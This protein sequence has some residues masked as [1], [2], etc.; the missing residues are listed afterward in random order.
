MGRKSV[1]LA[2][3]IS[4][5]R[6]GRN[7]STV[8]SHL[9]P[10]DPRFP[11]RFP[12]AKPLVLSLTWRVIPIIPS[13]YYYCY[14]YIYPD[15]YYVLIAEQPQNWGK[16]TEVTV[17]RVVEWRGDQILAKVVRACRFAIDKTHAEAVD[18]AKTNV[19]VLSAT[20]QG[21]LRLE[22]AAERRGTVVGRFGSFDVNYALGIETGDRSKIPPGALTPPI[23]PPRGRR[24]TGNRHFLGNAAR[25]EYP[26]FKQRIGEYYRRGV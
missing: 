11:P 10:P 15:I 24:N 1:S 12:Q 19:P 25:R 6:V 14:S 4:R 16:P 18:D 13:P 2:E 21:S 20:L 9:S 3:A 26:K 5:Y 17:P 7:L 23:G 8:G 22:P